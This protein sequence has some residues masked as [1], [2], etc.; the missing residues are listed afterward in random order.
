MTATSPDRDSTE[1]RP[2]KKPYRSPRLHVYG[3]IRDITQGLGNNMTN[4][5]Q[6]AM[7]AGFKSLP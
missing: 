6:G 4:D 3:N 7:G 2:G 5:G 1:G